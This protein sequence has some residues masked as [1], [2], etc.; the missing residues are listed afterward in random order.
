MGPGRSHR[1]LQGGRTPHNGRWKLSGCVIVVV[2]D[3]RSRLPVALERS[4][5]RTQ[6]SCQ[7]KYDNKAVDTGRKG[8]DAPGE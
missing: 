5:L 3:T 2:E 1:L 8:Q 6:V 7:R 4:V